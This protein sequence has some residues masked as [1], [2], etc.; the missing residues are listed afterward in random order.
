M[1][2]EAYPGKTFSEAHT[3]LKSFI[4]E[5]FTI[6]S[7]KSLLFWCFR[8]CPWFFRAFYHEIDNLKSILYK[9]S[10]PCDLV[11]KY[12]EKD[13]DKILSL[14]IIVITVP[15]KDLV[16]A[17]P[18]LGKLSLQICARINYI[19]KKTSLIIISALFS[20]ASAKAVAILHLKTELHRSYVLPVFINF[21]MVAAMLPIMAKLNAIIRS[22]C[23]SLEIVRLW[24]WCNVA[25]YELVRKE[26]KKIFY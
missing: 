12:I 20:W 10:Y 4:L 22:E 26:F 25:Q 14:S 9:N 1:K 18:C 17:P 11:D 3:K 24:D 21:S 2:T 19:T 6:G 23:M 7:I 8:L 15:K 5:T 16:I 13:L